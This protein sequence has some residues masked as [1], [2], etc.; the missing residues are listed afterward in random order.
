MDEDA[1][2]RAA[3]GIINVLAEHAGSAQEAALL[4]GATLGIL[5]VEE[6]V[7]IEEAMT[8]AREVRD[9]Y[10]KRQEARVLS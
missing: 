10:R 1:L 4:L 2:A 8:L 6:E 3:D 9:G 7:D 5:S